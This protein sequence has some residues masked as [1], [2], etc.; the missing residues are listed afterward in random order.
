MDLTAHIA[1]LRT[2]G[3]M[4]ADAAESTGL[5]APVPS[6]PGWTVR[7]LVGH[8]GTVH[9]WAAAQVAQGLSPVQSQAPGVPSDDLDLMSW[10]REGHA[11]LLLTLEQA[12]PEGECFT[13]LPDAAGG[14]RF[15]AR[16]QAHETAIHRIDAQCVT[17]L[18]TPSAP[19]FAVDGVNELLHGFFARR[20]SKLV[21]A[22]PVSFTLVGTD[23]TCAWRVEIGPEGA[24]TTDGDGE[25][26]GRVYGSA[27]ELYTLLWNRRGLD[28]L[29]VHGDRTGLELWRELAR[30]RF[31]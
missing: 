15:W 17:G 13:F 29:E 23:N 9:R 1:F 18:A 11:R 27:F 22:E 21:S 20:P 19:E 10:Y 7:D 31:R 8:V 24:V 26:D 3:M 16:R 25:S 14:T 5:S 4:L 12:D 30:V 28:G 6:C 2:D